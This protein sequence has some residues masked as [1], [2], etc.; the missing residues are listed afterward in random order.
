MCQEVCADD[1]EGQWQDNRLIRFCHLLLLFRNNLTSLTHLPNFLSCFLSTCVFQVQEGQKW[2]VLLP[3]IKT[4]SLKSSENWID[5]M[6]YE[7]YRQ[8]Q[9]ELKEIK[10]EYVKWEEQEQTN[11]KMF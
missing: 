10:Q 11:K 5:H 8:E 4:C 1:E 2:S 3:Y 6:K 9:K 7:K